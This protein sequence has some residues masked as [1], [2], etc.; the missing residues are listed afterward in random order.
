MY[1]IHFWDQKVLEEGE[2]E[3]QGGKFVV[4]KNCQKE[5]EVIGSS[6]WSNSGF[7]LFYSPFSLFFSFHFFL[8]LWVVTKHFKKKNH[9][10]PEEDEIFWLIR[11]SIWQNR[12]DADFS[13]SLLAEASLGKAS[14]S[15][16]FR[17][18]SIP[19]TRVHLKTK[20]PESLQESISD[21][22]L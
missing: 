17:E 21:R 22:Y 9:L 13:N 7:L 3:R 14:S 11:K 8:F 5:Q 12:K 4:D 20:P 19:N 16:L 6:P 2:R 1:K 10:K 18:P 15:R